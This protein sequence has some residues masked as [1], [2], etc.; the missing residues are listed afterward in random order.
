[1]IE[2][3]FH[4]LAEQVA[5]VLKEGMLSGRW[6]ETLPGRNRLAAELGVSHKTVEAAM[7][8][9]AAQGMLV[10]QGGGQRRRIVLPEGKVIRRKLR[11][12]ILTYDRDSRVFPCNLEL[13]DQLR[14]AGFVAD[15][16]LKTMADLGTDAGRLARFVKKTPADAWIVAGGSREV[17]EWFSQQDIAAIALFGRFTGLPIAASCPRIASAMVVAVRRLVALGHHRIVMI[18][19]AERRKPYPALVEQ[20]FLDELEAQGIKTG[21]YN[22]PDWE[23]TPA[24]LRGCLNT[25]FQHTPPTAVIFGEPRLFAAAQQH[26]ARSGIHAPRDVSLISSE[27]DPCLA[28]CDPAVSCFRWDSAPVIK[29]VMRWVKG[30]A[31]QKRED[32]R[33][34]LFDGEF[35]E[36]GTIGPAPGSGTKILPEG[37]VSGLSR[38]SGETSLE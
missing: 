32:K 12:R 5:E 26:L 9:L 6:R 19:Q 20:V 36:G 8:R 33:Q 35:V 4:S 25:L 16:A 22:L 31:A 30:V 11:V 13:L 24:G 34:V 15:F 21:S 27:M 23:G 38:K 2:R 1:M 7:R 28:W 18:A 14:M 17:L 10:S 3:K 37:K 29:R